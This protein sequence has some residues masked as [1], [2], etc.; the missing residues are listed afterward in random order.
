MFKIFIFS[1]SESQ[2]FGN[3]VPL[4]LL[5]FLT[6]L[7]RSCGQTVLAEGKKPFFLFFFFFSNDCFIICW[8][9]SAAATTPRALQGLWVLLQLVY[10]P[11][12]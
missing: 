4:S 8:L 1:F 11:C 2:A 7:V 3:V 6:I 5:R 12:F 9:G 10:V